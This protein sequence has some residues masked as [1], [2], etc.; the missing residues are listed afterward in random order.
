LHSLLKEI[1][2]W[3]GRQACGV[4]AVIAVGRPV[5][6]PLLYPFDRSS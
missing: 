4:R 3:I 2:E 6:S 5:V 1:Q